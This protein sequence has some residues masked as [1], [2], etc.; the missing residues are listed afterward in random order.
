LVEFSE[1][2]VEIWRIGPLRETAVVADV[3]RKVAS[4]A[5]ARDMLADVF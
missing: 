5:K 4:R 3:A 2:E 1:A